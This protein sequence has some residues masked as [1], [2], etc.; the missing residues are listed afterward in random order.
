MAERITRSWEETKEAWREAGIDGLRAASPN[1][2]PNPQD[3]LM[4]ASRFGEE[5]ANAY[6]IGGDHYKMAG[7][8]ELWDRIWRLG[9]DYFQGNIIKYIE[10]WKTKGG[11]ADLLKAKH[12]LEKYLELTAPPLTPEEPK[13]ERED[14]R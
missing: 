8:E 5:G 7:G 4:F 12:Y 9:L 1:G 10:R 11:R 13:Q 6:Q 2:Q 3:H 14:D